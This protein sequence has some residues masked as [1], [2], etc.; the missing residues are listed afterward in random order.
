MES[1]EAKPELPPPDDR[2][3]SDEETVDGD[4]ED[5]DVREDGRIADLLEEARAASPT[6]A[7]DGNGA[8]ANR[9]REL[10]QE[11]AE[12]ASE[13]GSVDALPRRAGSPVDSMLSVPDD[14]PSVQVRAALPSASA[15]CVAPAD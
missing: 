14:S 10:L 13:D 5:G 11:Q 2:G 12:T 1:V 3:S 15:A 6:P 4:H 7:P 9:Y 8:V